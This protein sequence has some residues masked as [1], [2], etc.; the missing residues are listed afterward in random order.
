MLVLLRIVRDAIDVREL[1]THVRDDACGGIVT[2]AGVVREKANDGRGVTGLSYEAHEE[3]ALAI[4]AEIV[5]ER[6]I[7]G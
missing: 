6:R 2:F 3:M 5:S 4:F 1:E 7:T